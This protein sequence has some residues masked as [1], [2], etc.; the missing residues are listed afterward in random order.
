MEAMNIIRLQVLQRDNTPADTDDSGGKLCYH[1]RL[2]HTQASIVEKQAMELASYQ[3]LCENLTNQV[4]K[5]RID[6]EKLKCEH[7][8]YKTQ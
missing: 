8:K 2:C 1:P 6:I 5:L 7:Q 4:K 3:S